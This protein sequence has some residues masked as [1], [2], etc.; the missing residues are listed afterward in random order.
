MILVDTS[1]WIDH[2]RRPSVRLAALLEEGEVLWHPFVLAELILGNLRPD[3]EVPLLLLDLPT[4]VVAEHDEALAF[5]RR[6]E[7]A[8]SG[9]GWVDVHLLCAAALS[10]A[11]LW[12]VDR[13][14]QD[15]AERLD[16]QA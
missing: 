13:R 9:I 6:H 16:L 1:V 15:V 7:L 8:G 2:L 4:A 5:V 14:L 11:R 3:S 10:R 12:S